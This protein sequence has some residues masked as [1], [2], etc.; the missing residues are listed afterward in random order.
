MHKLATMRL[1]FTTHGDKLAG[2]WLNMPISVDQGDCDF[3][4]GKQRHLGNRCNIFYL[5]VSVFLLDPGALP[6]HVAPASPAALTQTV[7][8]PLKHL[9]TYQ[10]TWIRWGA[11]LLVKVPV[12]HRRPARRSCG[13][14]RLASEQR[15]EA[16]YLHYTDPG[17]SIFY[18]WTL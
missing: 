2:N 1:C 9:P 7:G 12:H 6:S 4:I 18:I 13:E 16:L 15:C 5:S 14:H 3:F 8:W 17:K 10:R 11:F